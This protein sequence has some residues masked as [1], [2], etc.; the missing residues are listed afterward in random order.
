M[1]WNQGK[2]FIVAKSIARDLLAAVFHLL[3][4]IFH[5]A[6]SLKKTSTHPSSSM[7]FFKRAP[8]SAILT[9]T[10]GIQTAWTSRDMRVVVKPGAGNLAVFEYISL[11][12][13]AV[14]AVRYPE[15][16][17]M[18]SW[19]MSMRGWRNFKLRRC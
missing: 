6:P 13:L 8:S 3:Y 19:T 7:I 12:F 17:P 2:L 10:S 9:C 1:S 18:T 4:N 15:S 11:Y 14:A 5:T 16:R